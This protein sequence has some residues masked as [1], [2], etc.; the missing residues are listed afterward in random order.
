M[1][2]NPSNIAKNKIKQNK[3]EKENKNRSDDS[4]Q[5]EPVTE[6]KL[7]FCF[8]SQHSCSRSVGLVVDLQVVRLVFVNLVLFLVI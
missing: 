3:T 1:S 8:M 6:A 2:S 5:R 4:M 7:G